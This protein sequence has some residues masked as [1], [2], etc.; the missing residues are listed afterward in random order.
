M[1]L[2]S[3]W[4]MTNIYDNSIYYKL[5]NNYFKLTFPPL[6][7]ISPI[8]VNPEK[9]RSTLPFDALLVLI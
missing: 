6:F 2:P 1:L 5:I 4:Q 8:P 7:S 3:V 9:T